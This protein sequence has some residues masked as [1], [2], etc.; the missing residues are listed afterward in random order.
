MNKVCSAV[1]N[2]IDPSN[3]TPQKKIDL[4]NIYQS[5]F[6]MFIDQVQKKYSIISQKKE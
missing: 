6:E 5:Y 3:N 2:L 4:I 1:Q